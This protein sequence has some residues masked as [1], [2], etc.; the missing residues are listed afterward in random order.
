MGGAIVAVPAHHDLQSEHP[1]RR[2]GEGAASESH[3]GESREG[4]RHRRITE[5]GARAD[6][7]AFPASSSFWP[8]A[9]R[10]E[11][12][13]RGSYSPD[14]LSKAKACVSSPPPPRERAF[15][16]PQAGLAGGAPSLEKDPGVRPGGTKSE[17]RNRAR[18][19]QQRF[20][21][22][23]FSS[24][25]W[26]KFIFPTRFHGGGQAKGHVC[27]VRPWGPPLFP[28][29]SGTAG[30]E[31]RA[32]GV[33]WLWDLNPESLFFFPSPLFLFARGLPFAL[34]QSSGAALPKAGSA[35]AIALL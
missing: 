29:S 12:V 2:T 8:R 17:R 30:S 15:L 35:T 33:A 7:G 23:D 6:R 21:A 32:L 18:N 28:R 25:V 10:D 16:G 31:G 5:P 11:G 1:G 9:L 3:S 27:L 22:V 26:G 13:R 14:G 4:Y 20:G 24:G 19:P 34:I